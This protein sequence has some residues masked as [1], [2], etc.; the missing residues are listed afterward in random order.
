MVGS[1][2]ASTPDRSDL[3]QLLAGRGRAEYGIG[4]SERFTRA[5]GRQWHGRAAAAAAVEPVDK[6]RHQSRR[7]ASS[8]SDSKF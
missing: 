2:L 3:N 8:A 1:S 5:C 7:S 6:T 4:D